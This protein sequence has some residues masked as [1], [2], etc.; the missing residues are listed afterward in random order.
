MAVI[1]I[2]GDKNCAWVLE[3]R[4]QIRH[5]AVKNLQDLLTDQERQ[6]EREG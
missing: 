3:N 1:W 6:R 2:R 5:I 4:E